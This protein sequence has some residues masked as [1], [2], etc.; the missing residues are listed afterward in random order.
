MKATRSIFIKMNT[1]KFFSITLL[2]LCC[3]SFVQSCDKAA[4]VEEQVEMQKNQM[5]SYAE[6]AVRYNVE[7]GRA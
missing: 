5:E 3:F 1:L 7:K 4:A 2:F 6:M